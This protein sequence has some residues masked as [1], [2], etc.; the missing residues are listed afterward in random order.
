MA[1]APTLSDESETDAP[2][3]PYRWVMLA[4]VWLLYFA[5]AASIA[6]IAP[7]VYRVMLDLGMNRAEMGTVLAAWQLLLLIRFRYDER[8][9]LSL[10]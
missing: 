4:G 6:S 3:H 5:F 9:T 10:C 2:P 1:V 8:R 7:L